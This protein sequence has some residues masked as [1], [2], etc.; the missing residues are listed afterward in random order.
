MLHLIFS[1][2]GSIDCG[3]MKASGDQCIA[4]LPAAAPEPDLQRSVLCEKGEVTPEALA[5][6]IIAHEGRAVCWH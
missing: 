2:Q 1:L 4:M 5:D 3:A 6:L